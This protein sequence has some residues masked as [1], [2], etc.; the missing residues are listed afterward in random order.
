MI[1][2]IY[3]TLTRACSENRLKQNNNN[4]NNKAKQRNNKRTRH[5][6]F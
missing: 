3:G 1:I 4:N 5:L 2:L 6:G